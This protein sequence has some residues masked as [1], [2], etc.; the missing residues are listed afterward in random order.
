MTMVE[1]T[2]HGS[3]SLGWQRSGDGRDRGQQ[4]RQLKLLLQLAA[5]MV[6]IEVNRHGSSSW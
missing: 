5:E 6:E 4:P 2:Y 3:S 1:I